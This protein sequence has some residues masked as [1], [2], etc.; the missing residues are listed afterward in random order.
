MHL[1]LALEHFIGLLPLNVHAKQTNE[2][3]NDNTI[4]SVKIK[5]FF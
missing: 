2:N 3:I 5:H 1:F 4:V